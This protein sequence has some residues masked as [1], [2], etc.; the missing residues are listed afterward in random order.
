LLLLCDSQL[1][2]GA[3]QDESL[4]EALTDFIKEVAQSG[5]ECTRPMVLDVFAKDP[6]RENDT[7]WK[8][9][10]KVCRFNDVAVRMGCQVNPGRVRNQRV[11]NRV[12]TDFYLLVKP[13][14]M[15]APGV[16]E[17]E[18]ASPPAVKD[19]RFPGFLFG[20]TEED[21]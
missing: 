6:N 17:K 18:P 8:P 21:S 5:G 12:T 19:G 4:L 16:E 1:L 15:P 9:Q 10:W 11:I 20:E 2:A 13:E 14:L 7:D 3:G